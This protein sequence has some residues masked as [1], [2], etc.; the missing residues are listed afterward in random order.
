MTYDSAQGVVLLHGGETCLETPCRQPFDATD[1]W[2]WDGTTW[3]ELHPAV[4]PR[5]RQSASMAYDDARQTAVLYGLP[6]RVRAGH[7]W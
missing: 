2:A 7:R 4:S 5:L 6:P 1:T 3:T